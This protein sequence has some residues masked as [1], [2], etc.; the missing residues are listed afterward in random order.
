MKKMNKTFKRIAIITSASLLAACAM[1]P[2]TMSAFAADDAAITI[3]GISTKVAHTFEVY[4]VF[5]GDITTGEN[6]AKILSN[7]KWGASVVSYKENSTA[8]AQPVNGGD[9]VPE[10]FS[11]SL[12]SM[13]ARAV[14]ELFTLKSE[15]IQTMASSNGEASVTGLADGYYIIKDV[16]N[17]DNAN[18]ANS[19]WMVEVADSATIEIKNEIPTVDKQIQD[20]A[21]AGD[22]ETGSSDGWGES[23]DHAIN[24][25]FLF[26]LT[27]TIPASDD[28]AAYDTYKV[29]FNDTMSDGVTFESIE[30][31]S[32][33]GTVIKEYNADTNANG[34]KV[35]GV[36]NGD[37]GKAWTLTID[38][39]KQCGVTDLTK[40]A[41]I[42]VV[43]KAHLNEDAILS[44]E[45]GTD[46]EV[47]NNKVS[48]SYSNNPDA[49]GTGTTGL[50]KT[51]EDYVW[52]FTYKID[53]TKYKNSEAEENLFAG[54]G[55]T[56]YKGD[57][58]I[59]LIYNG[60]GTYTVAD[61][62]ATISTGELEAGKSIVT[63]MVSNGSGKFDIMGLDIGTYTL[64]ETLTPAGYNS[65]ENVTI[66]I[67]A[68]HNENAN[69]ASADLSLTGSSN[70]TNK[71]VNKSGQTL[72]GTGGI[73]TTIFYLGGGVMATIGG[74]Y[75]ISKRRMKKSEE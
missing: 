51:E 15:P 54:A 55:F 13:D 24:E 70:L 30:S 22:M 60:D 21:V 12:T 10:A 1:M 69:K 59:K 18:D 63:Q 53:N 23:A 32:V 2:A 39:I 9:A 64:K 7:L 34:Y 11:K 5:T 29:V 66:V 42:T 20:D 45:S 16:T 27:A 75:L 36:A 62:G 35:D 38:D 31:V 48:L 56:L 6:D 28:L 25:S 3:T 40:G 46:L 57:Q 17:L 43:Y 4:Q 33:G 74:V 71:I 47:N 52:A 49:T 50:G 14:I 65:C 26:K 19:A 68:A 37:A 8:A 73:G 44:N 41:T 61:Q 72:P 67:A 58:A